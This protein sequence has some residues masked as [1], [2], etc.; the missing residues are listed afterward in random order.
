MEDDP[1]CTQEKEAPWLLQLEGEDLAAERGGGGTS[2][3]R[4]QASTH[5]RRLHLELPNYLVA[6]VANDPPERENLPDM[7]GAKERV[8][9]V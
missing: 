1:C 4:Q 2:A 7:K 9:E 6:T 3:I 8:L 5:L